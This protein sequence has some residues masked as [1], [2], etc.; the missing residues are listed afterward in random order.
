MVLKG[1]C[2]AG[3]M[4]AEQPTKSEGAIFHA[5]ITSGKFQGKTA[6]ATPAGSLTISA[7]ALWPVGADFIC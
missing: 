3:L 6:P 4:T 2:L 7:S 5:A 1:V